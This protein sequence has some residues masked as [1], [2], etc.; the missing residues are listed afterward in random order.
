MFRWRALAVG[1]ATLLLTTAVAQEGAGQSDGARAKELFD[2]AKAARQGNRHAEACTLFEKSYALDAVPFLLA[3]LAE[4]D[5]IAGRLA[6]AYRRLERM[7]ADLAA[8][9]FETQVAK[10]EEKMSALLPRVP[11]LKLEVPEE[12]DGLV[13]AIDGQPSAPSSWAEALLRDVGSI[14]VIAEAP[15]Y[16]AF[17]ET[18]VLA[19]GKTTTLTIALVPVADLVVRVPEALANE[20]GLVVTVDGLALG[21]GAWGAP[22]V[23]DAGEVTIAATAPGYEPFRATESLARGEQREVMIALERMPT[24]V[25]VPPPAPIEASDPWVPVGWTALGVGSAGVVVWAVAGGIAIKKKQ[26]IGANCQDDMCTDPVSQPDIDQ[27][28]AV[29]DVATVGVVIAGVSAA[30]GV[31]ALVFGGEDEAVA[32]AFDAGGLTIR[33]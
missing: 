13:V 26:D 25:A 22:R 9:G 5:K 14:T 6:T 27:V 19:A 12:V 11:R 10:V 24:L 30:V 29:A 21:A 7:K 20:P 17:G 31:L 18:A 4:C 16:R 23:V 1:A 8:T 32:D 15:G 3:D 28:N 33:F 2:A